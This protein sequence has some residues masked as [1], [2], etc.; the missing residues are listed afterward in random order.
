MDNSFVGS[1]GE[2]HRMYIE[3]EEEESEVNIPH[4]HVRFKDSNG[5]DEI[6]EAPICITENSILLQESKDYIP[7]SLEEQ[8]ILRLKELL[9]SQ[10]KEYE[11]KTVWESIIESW[12]N[13]HPDNLIDISTSIPDYTTDM[14]EI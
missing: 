12:N 10:C 11:G 7:Y 6:F 5:L 3:I 8:D 1:Y 13:H 4:F 9:N 14:K 2:P